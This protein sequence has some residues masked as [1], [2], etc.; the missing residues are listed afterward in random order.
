MSKQARRRDRMVARNCR[1]LLALVATL[2]STS[3][4][5][6]TPLARQCRQ[7][8]ADA[9]DS[10]V[11]EG[12]RRHACR[13]Q[14]LRACKRQ[15]I[16]VCLSAA[17]ASTDDITARVARE[18]L[19]A[20]SNVTAVA[21][22]SSRIQLSWVD[23]VDR[24]TGQLIERTENPASGFNPLVTVGR[25][26]ESYLDG[27]LP[28]GRT[29]YY[30]LRAYIRNERVSPYS[31]V[32]SATTPVAGD[33]TPP[34]TPTGLSA[35]AVGCTQIAVS[36]SPSSDVGGSGLAGYWVLRNG[37]VVG[38]VNA[39]A[40]S[41]TDTGLA[42]STSYTYQVVALDNARN[43]SAL[44]IAR[45]ATTPACVTSTTATTAASTSTTTST[46]PAST[47]TTTSTTQPPAPNQPPVSNAG[48]NQFSQ[49]LISLSFDGSGAFDPDGTIVSYA[50]SFGDGGAASGRTVSHAYA[51]AGS[52][53]V[54]LTVTDN[55]DRTA[56]DTATASI[57]NRIPTAAAGP[58][59]TATVGIAASFNG[60]GSSD[61]DGT[62]ASYAWT[63][64]DGSSATG[65]V[66][67]HT[68]AA[69]G[70]YTASLTVTDNVGAT[71]TDTATVTVTA[72]PSSSGQLLW[73]KT[74]GVAGR[75]MAADRDGNFVVA[76]HF[77][78]TADFGGGPLSSALGSS[79]VFLAKYS[80]AGAHL[81][82]KRF[83]AAGAEMVKS[84]ALDANGN[85]VVTGSCNGTADLG[86]GPVASAGSNDIFVAKY[87]PAGAP[88]WSKIIGGTLDDGGYG[89]AVNA[90]GDPI[91]TGFFHG[92]VNFGGT[93]LSST[94]GGRETFV[95]KLAAADGAVRWAVRFPSPSDSAGWDVAVD[96]AGDVVAAG[97]FLGAVEFG[98]GAYVRTAGYTDVYLV[99]LSG[100]S[101]THVWSMAL[102]GT[103]DDSVSRVAVGPSG[104]I[105]VTGWF[106]DTVN[107][108]GSPLTSTAGSTDV[109]V[110]QYSPAGAH[111]WSRR[112]GSTSD[113]TASG[114]VI[115]GDSVAV[116][117][118]FGGTIDA[119]G[120]SLTSAGYRD[121]FVA[122]YSSTGTHR[123]SKRFGGPSD[124]FVYALAMDPS[125]GLG[126]TG[127]LTDT[128]AYQAVLL[129][130]AP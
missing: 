73:R 58:D 63:F 6:A 13:K 28:A 97:T 126:V 44:S 96:S 22:S 115:N 48:P 106:Y 110:A 7:A 55:G 103:R 78:G 98:G 83:G 90:A 30:R 120:G 93:M 130:L 49:T 1:A 108:G 46:T 51:S 59:Q 95:T 20:P 31:E 72:P 76:G 38:A 107:F 35:S 32:V 62:I 104:N 109:F 66:V 113:D 34:S 10:C 64:G 21:V 71:A 127:W 23:N 87:S 54:T 99:K 85:I 121:L 33:T 60:A 67:S 94:R 50:W 91:V 114:V 37:A 53:I 75:G 57:A 42:A 111:Q 41:T 25:N 26:V 68:Y 14:L 5:H 74:L 40:T 39:P 16:E 65:P 124:D 4:T 47:S 70:T 86:T 116:V 15:G 12:N 105:V 117:G 2:L 29:F 128:G 36:W 3:L 92:A 122:K 27:N 112:I 80:A 100:V 18:T 123:W 129:S 61:A 82:S 102:G 69:P 125:G 119:G 45:S 24:E 56:T 88:L 19:R 101:G 17:E 8:C 84:M 118:S 9:I 43:M 89:V 11:A 77:Q 79:D 52:Y 81:W